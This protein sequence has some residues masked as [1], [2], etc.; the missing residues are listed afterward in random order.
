MSTP[1]RPDPCRLRQCSMDRVRPRTTARRLLSCLE[2]AH[3]KVA[4]S[5]DRRRHLDRITS[6]SS[7]RSAVRWDLTGVACLSDTPPLRAAPLGEVYVRPSGAAG[8]RQRL[9]VRRPNAAR[10]RRRR[11]VRWQR[12]VSALGRQPRRVRQPAAVR[13]RRVDANAEEARA[14][15]AR[16]RHL[17]VPLTAHASLSSLTRA[18]FQEPKEC[19]PNC[20]PRLWAV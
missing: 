16:S 2:T 20:R 5:H 3:R 13:G 19:P 1:L 4:G 8:A 11:A 17:R 6:N 7:S 18:A 14:V 9:S 10:G 12:G 15:R